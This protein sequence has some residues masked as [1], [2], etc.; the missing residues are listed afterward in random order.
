MKNSPPEREPIIIKISRILHD[1]L[2]VVVPL[3]G[4]FEVYS[5]TNEAEE[6]WPKY[7]QR[8]KPFNRIEK[9]GI[10]VSDLMRFSLLGYILPNDSPVEERV[11]FVA[12]CLYTSLSA[13]ESMVIFSRRKSYT[14]DAQRTQ[15][16]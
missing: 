7:F 10:F 1:P 15:I 5:F 16:R 2:V 9:L 8:E 3:N 11:R 6:K 4:S 12:I 13:I 14:R